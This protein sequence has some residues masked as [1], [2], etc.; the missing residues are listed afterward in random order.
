MKKLNE[1]LLKIGFKRLISDPCAYFKMNYLY[2][3]S[4]CR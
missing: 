2:T 4:L 3:W 1:T